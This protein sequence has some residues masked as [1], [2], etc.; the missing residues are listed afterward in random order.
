MDESL[1]QAV[2]L[3]AVAIIVAIAA[4]QFRLPYTVG[5]V[6]V[7]ATLT[8]TKPDFG[9]HLTHDLIFDL[10]LPPLLFEAALS[11]PWRELRR[12]Y[13]P[14]TV[15]AT[16]GTVIA[17]CV[18][19]AGMIW[20][21]DWPVPSALVFGVLIAA[22]D[23]VAIIA[24]FK[25]NKFKGRLCLLV[26]SESLLNDGAATVLFVM[27]LAWA[28]SAGHAQASLEM[29]TTL[30][31][32]VLGGVII[33]A[34]FGGV[35]ILVAKRTSEHLIEAALTTVAAYGSFLA[36]EYFDVSGVLATVTAGLTIGNL[37]LLSTNEKGYLS[38]KGREFVIALW[39][40]AAFL[41]NSVVFLLIGIDVAA[42]PF[43]SYGLR[44][45]LA[46]V[47]L[48]LLGRGLVVYPLSLLFHRSRWAISLREQHV[49]WWG[50]LRGAQGLALALSL[51]PTLPLRHE[52]VVV[53][54]GVVAFSIVVQGSRCLFCC[55]GLG[56][57]RGSAAWQLRDTRGN[58]KRL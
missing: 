25:D 27:A 6:I 32:I 26:E 30:V 5:L 34:A 11:I 13:F 8:L 47:A 36:A 52:I 18:V 12:D 46:S 15:L 21:L 44:V 20:L 3:L 28:Q 7:G 42:V 56:F 17:A 1:R 57:R 49:L 38:L 39:E 29:V 31:R 45:L 37:D 53:T 48:V 19:T 58:A 35:A 54:F 16:L 22:T 33:G 40:F 23:P 41:A 50:G 51:P 43:E 9:L 2:A 4:R 14:I 55:E 10:I 24:M